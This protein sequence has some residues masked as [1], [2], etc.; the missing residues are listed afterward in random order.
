VI[1]DLDPTRGRRSDE[2]AN[3]YHLR[4][5]SREKAVPWRRESNAAVM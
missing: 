2:C 5:A 1:S 4:T 3:A